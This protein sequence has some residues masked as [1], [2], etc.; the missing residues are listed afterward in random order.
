MGDSLFTPTEARA[1]LELL[2]KTMKKLG[3]EY[4]MFFSQQIRW[5]PT[6][7]QNETEA[8]IR[9]Y[10]KSPPRQTS[11]R[12]RFNTLVHRYRTSQERW[13]RR[14][15]QLEEQGVSLRH[16]Y[17][18]S[19]VPDRAAERAVADISKPQVLLATTAREGSTTGDQ[20][21]DVYSAYRQA[22]KARGQSISSLSYAPFAN[23]VGELLARAKER[24]G[25]KDVELRVTEVGGKVT[26]SVR[27]VTGRS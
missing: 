27:S 11:D 4:E 7:T 1:D 14:R 21:R 26:L 18:G 17:G 22:R 5:P 6:R 24:N 20:M 9:H 25:G 8:I 3:I 23:K 2:D 13:A 15:R 10:Q 16:R 12:Y 19:G